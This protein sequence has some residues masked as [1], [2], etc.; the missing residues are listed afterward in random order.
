MGGPIDLTHARSALDQLRAILE[1]HPNVMERTARFLASEPTAA[2]L[3]A[4][5]AD[6]RDTPVRIPNVLLDRADALIEPMEKHLDLLAYSR[7]NRASII[8]LA[9]GIGLVDLESRV[10]G[11]NDGQE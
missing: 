11:G 6:R 5:M 9:L 4:I 8:R 1:A 3:E 7:P 2:T 10:T